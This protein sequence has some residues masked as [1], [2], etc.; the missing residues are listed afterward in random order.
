MN[1]HLERLRKVYMEGTHK[2]KLNA[3]VIGDVGS[4]KTTLMRTCPRPILI[5]SFDPG[6][7][8]VRTLV[9]GIDAGWIIVDSSFEADYS[10]KSTFK[11]WEAEMNRLLREGVFEEVGTYVLDSLT[12]WG[13]CLLNH[14]ILNNTS[15]RPPSV[16]GTRMS[17]QSDYGALGIRGQ[18]CI[19]MLCCL[20][21]N[22]ILTGHLDYLEDEVTG[23]T[24]S[25]VTI[26]GKVLKVILPLM[27]DEVYVLRTMTSSKGR[28]RKLLTDADG[29][30]VGKT[31]IGAGV[32]DKYEE[33][34]ISK[35]MVKAGL[36]K[37][38]DDASE[39]NNS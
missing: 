10:S 2:D 12:T 3:L 24:R 21:C 20:P 36:L 25:A 23:M 30:Y 9:E 28:E 29:I 7:S 34:D 37:G 33:P 17:N 18:H 13:Q 26:P 38:E 15:S 32:F 1:E 39:N 4:G 27:F 5:H 6:G 19:S 14:I 8:R 35:L 31:R 16:D 11:L 22:V